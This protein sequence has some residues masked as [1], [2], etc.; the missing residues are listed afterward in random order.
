M[1]A[2][3]TWVNFLRSVLMNSF[4][5]K[6]NFRTQLNIF[7]ILTII[8]FISPLVVLVLESMNNY[9]THYVDSWYLLHV[10]LK[11]HISKAFGYLIISIS[12]LVASTYCDG[13]EIDFGLS[14]WMWRLLGNHKIIQLKDINFEMAFSTQ[15]LSFLHCL[16]FLRDIFYWLSIDQR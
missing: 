2:Y 13:I 9:N 8:I 15:F 11:V 16:S 5:N 7:R 14:K 4:N 1:G 6:W 10:L 12:A 3:L